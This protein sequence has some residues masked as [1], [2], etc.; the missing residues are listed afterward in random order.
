IGHR[1]RRRD[2]RTRRGPPDR[3]EMQRVADESAMPFLP[4]YAAAV[5]HRADDREPRAVPRA[6]D[7]VEEELRRADGPGDR[8]AA[9]HEVEVAATKGAVVHRHGRE[10]VAR[11][12]DVRRR[13]HART[14]WDEGGD[15]Q[16]GARAADTEDDAEWNDSTE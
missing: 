1:R 11:H 2:G 10:P 6:L 3:D 8:V 15:H 13:H 12:V 16:L 9:L 5:L 4:A 14:R 7:D